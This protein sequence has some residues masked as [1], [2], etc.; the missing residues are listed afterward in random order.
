MTEDE[1]T[2][3]LIKA[4]SIGRL[5]DVRRLVDCGADVNAAN[6]YGDSLLHMAAR[7]GN[8]AIAEFLV[9]KGAA[10]NADADNRPTDQI[11]Y[12]PLLWA[13]ECGHVDMVR[14]LISKGADVNAANRYG[15]TPLFWAS[16][17]GNAAIVEFLISKGAEVNAANQDGDTALKLAGLYGHADVLKVL[18]GIVGDTRDS[19]AG[20]QGSGLMVTGQ[21]RVR[22]CRPGTRNHRHR[23][24]AVELSFAFIRSV[25]LNM[26]R[27]P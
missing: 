18:N 12:T 6:K 11:G 23:Y 5:V 20:R 26:R 3:A 14:F 2:T 4:I 16:F 19:G 22:W 15:D 25:R 13:A 27:P 21:G 9:S 7:T 17:D 10:V 8:V 1:M 24:P